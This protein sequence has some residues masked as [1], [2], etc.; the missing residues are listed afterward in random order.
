MAATKALTFVVDKIA[1]ATMSPGIIRARITVKKRTPQMRRVSQATARPRSAAG[2]TS[3][4]PNKKHPSRTYGM[5]GRD[6]L[7]RF[8]QAAT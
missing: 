4:S 7:M 8:Y 3:K 2:R 5:C 6:V 1:Y